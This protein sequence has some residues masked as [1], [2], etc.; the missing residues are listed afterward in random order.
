LALLIESGRY[1]KHL[2]RMRAFYAERRE[3][4][5]TALARHAPDLELSGMA[6]GFHAVL[7]LPDGVPEEH[8]VAGCAEHSVRVYPMS[9]YRADGATDPPQLVIGFGNVSTGDIERGVRVIVRTLGR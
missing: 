5:V 7:H 4:L 1:D 9:N 6:A 8:V 3:T 2:R